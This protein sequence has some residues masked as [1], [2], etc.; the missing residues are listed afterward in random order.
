[1]RTVSLLLIV[2]VSAFTFIAVGSVQ[3]QATVGDP[4]AVYYVYLPSVQNG[5]P[6]TS[7]AIFSVT[8][9]DGVMP[10]QYVT[11]SGFNFGVAQYAVNGVVLIEGAIPSVAA[12]N[13]S[14]I[15]AMVPFESSPGRWPVQVI[16]N[17]E[18][19]NP[20]FYSILAPTPTASPTATETP[21]PSPT[22]TPTLTPSATI[23]S[24]ET[25]TLTPTPTITST[26]T[27]TATATP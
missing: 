4:P 10:G 7:P 3:G 23:T 12:W 11:I 16:A 17:N 19:S 22:A 24:T 5:F 20:F 18:V 27:P 26:E 14:E 21:T 15:I 25:P 8:P 9:L 1:M 2:L 6:G 13:D